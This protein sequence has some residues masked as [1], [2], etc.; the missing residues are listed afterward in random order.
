MKEGKKEHRKK[1]GKGSD[2]EKAKTS[3]QQGKNEKEIII[4]K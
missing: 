1:S 3:V 4:N 2:K